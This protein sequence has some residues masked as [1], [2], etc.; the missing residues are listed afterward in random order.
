MGKPTGD[1]NP[2]QASSS[3]SD[4]DIEMSKASASKHVKKTKPIGINM[5]DTD[6]S[7]DEI[8]QKPK[9]ASLPPKAQ[10]NLQNMS[11]SDDDFTGP[12]RHQAVEKQEAKTLSKPASEKIKKEKKKKKNKDKERKKKK[13]KK[14]KKK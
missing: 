3:E 6:S 4:S 8:D 12:V 9:K 7:D 1:S 14:K 2:K 5:D 10:P 13:K 11:S